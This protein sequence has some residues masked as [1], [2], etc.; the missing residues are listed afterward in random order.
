MGVGVMNSS[1]GIKGFRS[2][3]NLTRRCNIDS[4]SAAPTKEATA[5]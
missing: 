1:Q 2:S 3:A 5:R 4:I